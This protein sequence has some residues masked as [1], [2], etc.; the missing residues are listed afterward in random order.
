MADI[1][2]GHAVLDDAEWIKAR[3][4]LLEE[5]KAFCKARMALA[6]KRQ[7]L[8]WRKV[9]DYEFDTAEGKRKLSSLFREGGPRDLIIY[10]MMMGKD[11]TAGCKSCSFFLDGW[12]GALPH[13]LPRINVAAVAAAAPAKINAVGA[14][15]GWGFPMLS[16]GESGFNEDFGVSFTAEQLASGEG[17]DYNYGRKWKFGSQAPGLSVFH[18]AENGD[19][20][21]SYSTFA[22]GLSEVNVTFSLLDLIPEGRNERPNNRPMYWVKHKSEY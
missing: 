8:P 21:H 2:D 12:N 22:A 5:E 14:A 20:F 19:V 3:Q 4:A 7:A 10:H 6:A 16:S 17:G 15:K 18:K 11:A 1:A 13:I 9:K